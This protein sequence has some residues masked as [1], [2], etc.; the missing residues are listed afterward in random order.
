VEKMGIKLILSIKES[1]LTK[2]FDRYEY[3]MKRRENN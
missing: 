1:I 2:R 3:D